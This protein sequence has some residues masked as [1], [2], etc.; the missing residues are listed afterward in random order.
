MY[1]YMWKMI[2][3][4]LYQ[5]V[6]TTRV[7]FRTNISQQVLDKLKKL[8]KEHHTHVN[9]LIENGLLQ[10]IQQNDITF[11]KEN[12]PSDRVQFKTTYDQELLEEVKVFAQKH[13]LFINDV[14]EYSTNKI[15]ISDVK[16]A[17]YRYR[18]E[19]II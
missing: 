11:N 2:N 14:I 9:Y 16:D 13:N 19:K 6:D 18:I 1:S 17:N 15:I 5:T 10:L 4:K 3:G 8:A 12:R 7:K